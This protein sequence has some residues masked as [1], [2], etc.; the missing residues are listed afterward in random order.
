MAQSKSGA[1]CVDLTEHPFRARLSPARA[2]TLTILSWRS[3]P[4]I[5]GIMPRRILALVLAIAGA[6]ACSTLPLRHERPI[7][8]LVLNMH[9]GKD[10]SGAANLD[11]VAALVK[12]T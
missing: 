2:R 10:A 8:V 7:R 9:A 5:L 3:G 6:A 12:S 4:D 1:M 11:G